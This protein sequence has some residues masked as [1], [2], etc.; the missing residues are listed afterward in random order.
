MGNRNRG[1]RVE[2]DMS[3]HILAYRVLSLMLLTG[4]LAVAGCAQTGPGSAAPVPYES[5]APAPTTSAP[6]PTASPVPTQPG[7]P[8]PKGACTGVPQTQTVTLSEQ[9][10]GRQVCVATGTQLEIYLKGT[11]TD[12]W[13]NPV[14]D[15]GVLRP[16]ASGKGALAVG[17][18][19]GFYVAD[20]PG[21]TRVTAFRGSAHFEVDVSVK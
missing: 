15:S 2:P 19:A 4:T 14:P 16:V 9:D 5:S 8:I 21:Q 12:K 20:H 17:V 18:S 6:S 11:M 13:S 10:N 7:A 3:R 1:R